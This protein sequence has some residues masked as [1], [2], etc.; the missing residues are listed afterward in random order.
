[1]LIM[2]VHPSRTVFVASDVRIKSAAG[3]KEGDH[4]LVLMR[5]RVVKRI[6][7]CLVHLLRIC[8]VLQEQL[9]YLDVARHTR[10]VE[11]GVLRHL[12]PD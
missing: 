4:F 8:T 3:Q 10:Q 9:Y 7:S 11:R 2:F 6:E 12:V 5:H 1:M